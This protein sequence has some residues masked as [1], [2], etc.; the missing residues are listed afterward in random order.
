MKKPNCSAFTK[1]EDKK[2]YFKINQIQIFTHKDTL[3][4]FRPIK[5]YLFGK[6][7]IKL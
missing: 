1:N 4:N 3:T 2:K 5:I 7:K 6:I